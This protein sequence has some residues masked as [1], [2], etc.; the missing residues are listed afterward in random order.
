MYLIILICN[1][2]YIVDGFI[3]LVIKVKKEKVGKKMIVN[4]ATTNFV[5]KSKS[6]VKYPF[7]SSLNRHYF[8]HHLGQITDQ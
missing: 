6:K 1:L 8:H 3:P 4:T 5:N 2:F 7:Y